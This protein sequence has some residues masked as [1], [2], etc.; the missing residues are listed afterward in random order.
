MSPSR[1]AIDNQAT[2]Q[3]WTSAYQAN[4]VPTLQNQIAQ[5]DD[6]PSVVIDPQLIETRPPDLDEALMDYHT[7]SIVPSFIS[8]PA[9]QTAVNVIHQLATA[10][11]PSPAGKTLQTAVSGL[12]ARHKLNT[13]YAEFEVISERKEEAATQGLARVMGDAEVLA[14]TEKEAWTAAATVLTLLRVK[15]RSQSTWF[16][17]PMFAQC[18]ECRG[19]IIRYGALYAKLRALSGPII[20]SGDAT[21]STDSLHF[22]M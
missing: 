19:D 17:L 22:G 10:A 13:G 9:A 20:P 14:G 18:Q 16:R 21:V 5:T 6:T 15:V 3:F 8:D 4:Q 1:P 2:L 7:N 11:V 12:S